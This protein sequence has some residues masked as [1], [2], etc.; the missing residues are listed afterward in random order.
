LTEKKKRL[1]IDWKKWV[2]TV[3]FVAACSFLFCYLS[4]FMG[5]M[6]LEIQKILFGKQVSKDDY[7]GK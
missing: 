7:Y 6:P 1:I 3:H 4:D 2:F 5:E